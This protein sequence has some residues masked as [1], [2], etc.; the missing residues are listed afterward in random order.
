MSADGFTSEEIAAQLRHKDGNV[1]RA[2]YI[3][4]LNDQKR[5]RVQRDQ[6]QALDAR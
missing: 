6:P 2:V 1:T 4:E 5:R 3:H